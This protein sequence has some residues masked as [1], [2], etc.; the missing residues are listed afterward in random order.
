MVAENQREQGKPDPDVSW[1][2]H[3]PAIPW[4]TLELGSFMDVKG[5]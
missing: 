3:I 5:H 2:H 1:T 4:K